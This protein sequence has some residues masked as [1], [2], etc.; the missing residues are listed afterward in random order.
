MAH[1]RLDTII[2]QELSVKIHDETG[3]Q[4]YVSSP[5]GKTVYPFITIGRS[6][7]LNVYDFKASLGLTINVF[8][9]TAF[10]THDIASSIADAVDDW[11][12]DTTLAIMGKPLVDSIIDEGDESGVYASNLQ[13]TVNYLER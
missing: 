1:S 11:Y 13:I 5:Q 7:G 6:G 2:I 4:P 3:I 8:S 9:D 12:S 10:E